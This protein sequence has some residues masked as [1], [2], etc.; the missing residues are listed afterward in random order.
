MSAALQQ[1]Y[2]SVNPIDWVLKMGEVIAKSR[3]FSCATV[4][5]GQGLALICL[6]EEIS[7]LECSRR[8]HVLGDGKLTMKADYM[9]HNFLTLGGKFEWLKDGSDGVLAQCR[10]S[11][12]NQTHE[13]SYAIDDA[14]KE[15]IY[16]AGSRWEKAPGDMLRAR[17]ATKA[18]RMV[19]PS[20]IAGMV[21]DEEMEAIGGAAATHTAMHAATSP[22][23]GSFTQSKEQQA[24][25]RAAVSPP[26]ASHPT[27]MTE[28]TDPS[29]LAGDGFADASQR[30]AIQ[31][32]FDALAL[33][34]ATRAQI[35]G[36]YGV[37]V[38][39]SLKR[40]DAATLVS[41]LKKRLD[42]QQAIVDKQPS[43]AATAAAST[44]AVSAASPTVNESID[45]QAPARE[46]DVARL[47][48]RIGKWEQESPGVTQKIVE[49]LTAC[50]FSK[51]RE[52]TIEQINLLHQSVVEKNLD[53]FFNRYYQTTLD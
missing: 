49:R 43:V 37:T 48:E 13:V 29:S 36:K 9:R 46:E 25:N 5:Q 11:F 21:T 40:E 39:R 15:G 33:D 16:K 1:I 3:M 22:T 32:S 28:K 30:E 51:F 17:C 23:V 6:T 45:L 41:K 38:I 10:V 27:A 20:A 7:I 24:K 18:I 34:D 52:L 44:A 35:L 47:K 31:S 14:K 4:E 53:L 12:A 26:I 2:Q 8:Y 50:G 19:C 42:E